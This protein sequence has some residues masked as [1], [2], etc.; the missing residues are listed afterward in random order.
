VTD[1]YR[2]G[3]RV[4]EGDPAIRRRIDVTRVFTNRP[5]KRLT[6]QQVHE[7]TVGAV[8]PV[9]E[10]LEELANTGWLRSTRNPDDFGRVVYWRDS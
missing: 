9:R 10:L 5:G 7:H 6:A 8:E 4:A 3:K 2:A 1:V